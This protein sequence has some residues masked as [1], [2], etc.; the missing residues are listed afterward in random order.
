M[1]NPTLLFNVDYWD[2]PLDGLCKYEGE[3][4]YFQ[5][6]EDGWYCDDCGHPKIAEGECT[7]LSECFSTKK[8]D[9]ENDYDFDNYKEE[10]FCQAKGYRK[11]GMYAIPP[12]SIL[13][14]KISHK[15]F[16]FIVYR[17]IFPS[18]LWYNFFLKFL[19]HSKDRYKESKLIKE[20]E[21]FESYKKVGGEIV[22]DA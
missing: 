13:K 9:C 1:V 6:I 4:Y 8:G 5:I 16:L 19:D 21:H 17:T 12:L 7:W 2:G 11:W 10:D 20:F 22:N 15:L 18:G 14:E 3:I